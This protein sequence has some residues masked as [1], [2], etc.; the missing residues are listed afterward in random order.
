MRIGRPARAFKA[1][2]IGDELKVPAIVSCGATGQTLTG[3]TNIDIVSRDLRRA[4]LI[5][6]VGAPVKPARSR[7]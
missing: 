3:R 6:I 5:Q 1:Q 4:V 2:L 7:W